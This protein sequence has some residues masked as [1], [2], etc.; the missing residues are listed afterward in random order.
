MNPHA[1]AIA[2]G[3]AGLP[4]DAQVDIL[5]SITERPIDIAELTFLLRDRSMLIKLTYEDPDTKMK[6]MGSIVSLIVLLRDQKH[7]GLTGVAKWFSHITDP[8]AET[9]DTT[10]A[11]IA[12]E[13]NALRK[14]FA[15]MPSMPTVED[16]DAITD[17]GGGH[18]F[19][20]LTS[21]Q[22]AKARSDFDKEISDRAT[23]DLEAQRELATA[24]ENARL[25]SKRSEAMS[26]AYATAQVVLNEKPAITQDELAA[27]FTSKLSEVWA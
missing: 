27:A 8:R 4:D 19:K 12:G 24:R 13:F 11:L 23:A 6:W 2:L 9:F 20:G 26:E 18:P 16:F 17:L 3:I 15:G 5:Q 25:I 7:P 21:G 10:Q 14:S 22:L 1:K